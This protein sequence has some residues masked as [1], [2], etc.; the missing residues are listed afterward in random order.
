MDFVESVK[1][2]MGICIGFALV[3]LAII[4]IAVI[5]AWVVGFDIVE[6]LKSMGGSI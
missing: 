3:R 2:G 5:I 1:L 4:G 6:I